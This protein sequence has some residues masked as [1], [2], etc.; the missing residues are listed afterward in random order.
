MLKSAI[1]SNRDV[2]SE[3]L[4]EAILKEETENLPP[5]LSAD[6]INDLVLKRTRARLLQISSG[7]LL[8]LGPSIKTLVQ[9]RADAVADDD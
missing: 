8:K 3:E 7:L 6:E 1:L 4:L 2:A 5:Y 9:A